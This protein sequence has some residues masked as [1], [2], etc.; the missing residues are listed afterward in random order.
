MFCQLKCAKFAAIRADM[1]V[2][3]I[4]KK[5]LHTVRLQVLCLCG[6][7]QVTEGG[8]MLRGRS[9]VLPALGQWAKCRGGVIAHRAWPA[10]V[11]S[12]EA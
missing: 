1:Y 5:H 9:G 3:Y 7:Q 4:K 10:G 12:G 6:M 2:D 11:P 8:E